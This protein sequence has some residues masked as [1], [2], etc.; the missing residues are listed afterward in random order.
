M[1]ANTDNESSAGA[2]AAGEAVPDFETALAELER[3]VQQLESGSLGLEPSLARFEHGISLLRRCYETLETAEQRIEMLTGMDAD[4]NPRTA[5]FPAV[6]TDVEVS[7]QLEQTEI[8]VTSERPVPRKA[9]VE[10]RV[11][12]AGPAHPADDT[13][14]A[15]EGPRL[16]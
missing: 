13:D 5:P 15:D 12:E 1:A 9:S 4:G 6:E 11:P 3:I 7:V 14:D 8:E 16:F 2:A 10:K